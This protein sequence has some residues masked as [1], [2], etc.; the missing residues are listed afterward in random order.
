MSTD[1]RHDD[2]GTSTELSATSS[3]LQT[4]V[5]HILSPSL[6]APNRVTLN[7]LPLTIKI[8]DLKTRLSE[9]LPNRPRPDIQ[10]LIYRGKP[11]A[12]NEEQLSNIVEPADGRVHTMHLVLPPNRAKIPISPPPNL[13]SDLN[14]SPHDSSGLR[15]RTNNVEPTTQRPPRS[16]QYHSDALVSQ[17]TSLHQQVI[18]QHQQLTAQITQN[19]RITDN[20]RPGDIAFS[21]ATSTSNI[22]LQNRPE[23]FSLFGSRP[24]TQGTNLQ[25]ERIGLMP[26][27]EGRNPPGALPPS[28]R[29]TQYNI[30]ASHPPPIQRTAGFPPRVSNR[31]GD[32][33]IG[34]APLDENRQQRIAHLLE[35][36]FNMEGQLRRGILPPID[37]ISHIRVQLYQILDEQYHQPLSPRD[38][39]PEALL[40][41]LASLTAQADQIRILR[42]R[43]P[44]FSPQ[45]SLFSPPQTTQDNIQSSVYLLSSPSGYHAVLVPPA[46]GTG[47]L[48]NHPAM[49]IFHTHRASPHPHRVPTPHPV[50]HSATNAPAVPEAVNQALNQ[51]ALR[52]QHRPRLGQLSFTRFLRRLWFF[53]RLYFLCYLLSEDGTWFRIILVSLSVLTTLLSETDIPQRLQRAIIDP[54]QRHLESL[55]PLDAHH[56][57]EINIVPRAGNTNAQPVHPIQRNGVD[58]SL[59]PLDG[60]QQNA[61]TANGEA[62]GFLHGLRRAERALALLLATLVPGVG[63]RHVAARNAAVAARQNELAA[64]RA[65]ENQAREQQNE[66]AETQNNEADDGGADAEPER[67]PGHTNNREENPLE[68]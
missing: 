8:F 30:T 28:Y 36:I 62:A 49:P 9:M 42:A 50:L 22:S 63:E 61:A 13:F 4:V 54:L 47:H 41:R 7:D 38:G 3:D 35:Y 21:T 2:M 64:R 59:R 20:N 16:P 57:R 51:A 37:E 24:G 32:G 17:V 46:V 67:R 34:M 45:N 65:A 29:T 33:E 27:N 25:S 19:A 14:T 53:V 10:R 11:L 60:T 18:T 31:V 48:T 66:D 12:D 52:R 68:A 5:L 56:P 40:G 1:I 43:S 44:S 6:E 58:G 26:N 55:L 39:M 15:A 23:N